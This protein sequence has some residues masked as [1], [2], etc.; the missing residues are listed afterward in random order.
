MCLLYQAGLLWFDCT[1]IPLDNVFAPQQNRRLASCCSGLHWHRRCR[2]VSPLRGCTCAMVNL[3]AFPWLLVSL[4]FCAKHSASEAQGRINIPVDHVRCGAISTALNLETT[5]KHR[6]LNLARTAVVVPR[7]WVAVKK[8]WDS[9]QVRSC[10]I[11]KPAHHHLGRM[12]LHMSDPHCSGLAC[13]RSVNSALPEGSR[14]SQERAPTL[15]ELQGMKLRKKL[16]QEIIRNCSLWNAATTHF[17]CRTLT[18]QRLHGSPITPPLSFRNLQAETSQQTGYEQQVLS[19]SSC[20]KR[21]S[22]GVDPTQSTVSM[23]LPSAAN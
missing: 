20:V 17:W 12:A 5:L 2:R 15:L 14:Q 6:Q 3:D 11:C 7:S 1:S 23:H 8:S 18:Q 9:V 13:L 4:W 19:T 22:T 21:A 10:G 16:L